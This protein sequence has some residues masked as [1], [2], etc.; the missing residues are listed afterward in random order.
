MSCI[1]P[2]ALFIWKN[3]LWLKSYA[4]V[5]TYY[6]DMEPA[7]SLC[8]E[9]K[10]SPHYVDVHAWRDCELPK[11]SLELVYP[12]SAITRTLNDLCP[13]CRIAVDMAMEHPVEFRPEVQKVSN[14]DT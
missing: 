13:A 12:E 6:L 8:V 3:R 14:H 5:P 4:D 2:R 1:S 11:Y 9:P 7:V 10:R